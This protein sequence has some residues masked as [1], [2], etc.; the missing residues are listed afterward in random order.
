MINRLIKL[1][2]RT[3]IF[4]F[5]IQAQMVLGQNNV[6]ETWD[7]KYKEINIITLLEREQNMLTAQIMTLMQ[8]SFMQD[9]MDTDSMEHLL[10]NGEN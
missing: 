2:L 7:S 3:L 6:W 8:L 5:T 9:K 4:I 1:L 10:E